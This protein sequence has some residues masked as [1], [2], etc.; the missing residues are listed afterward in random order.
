M[1]LLKIDGAKQSKNDQYSLNWLSF[2]KS[3][4]HLFIQLINVL[5]MS[6]VKLIFFNKYAEKPSKID[7]V[8]N[9]GQIW[10]IFTKIAF[11][12]KH[13]TNIVRKHHIYN[14]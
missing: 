1:I 4:Y 9:N 5:I 11:L 8:N 10:K 6:S 3:K 2:D 14:Q 13:S 7:K 12:P